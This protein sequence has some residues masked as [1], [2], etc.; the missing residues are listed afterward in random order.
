MG[1]SIKGR[2]G[3]ERKRAWSEFHIRLKRGVKFFE[4]ARHRLDLSGASGGGRG[5]RIFR[6]ASIGDSV[7]RT[8]LL[9]I[10]R[11][12]GGNNERRL[13]TDVFVPDIEVGQEEK[14]ID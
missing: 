5:L 4:V 7:Q 2:G 11:Q 14:V 8:E 9:W 6:K 10:I 3:L 13:V 12:F 1:R